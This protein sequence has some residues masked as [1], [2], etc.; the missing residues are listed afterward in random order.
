MSHI[1]KK[2]PRLLIQTLYRLTYLADKLH[3]IPLS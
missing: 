3:Q 1:V 2:Y